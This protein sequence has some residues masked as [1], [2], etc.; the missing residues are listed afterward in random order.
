MP[1]S[2]L[3]VKIFLG[4]WV[5]TIAVLGSW[6]L[7]GQY[8][9][10]LVPDDS[11][12]RHGETPPRL[13]VRLLYDLQNQTS[14]K[15]PDVIAEAQAKRGVQVYFLDASG[16]DILGRRV[17]KNVAT[18]AAR[19]DTGDRRAFIRDNAR[20]LVAHQLYREDLGPMRSVLVLKPSRSRLVNELGRNL[21]LRGALAVLVSGLLC[22]LLSR[23]LT[24]RLGGLRQ[25]AAKLADGDLAVRLAV[26]GRGGDET[27]DLARDFNRMAA[28]LQQRIDAQRRLLAD[29]SHEL[30]SPLA[31]LRV[32]LA[33]AEQNPTAAGLQLERIEREASRLDELIAEL[34][35]SQSDQLAMDEHIDLVPLLRDLC[36]DASFEGRESGRRVDLQTDC[37]Q[38][39]VLGDGGRLRKAFDNVLR[40]ALY[41]S[42]RDT[43]VAVAISATAG[44]IRVSVQ[45]QGPGIP[46]GELERIFD[47]F[48]RVDSARARETGGYGLGLAIAR[49]A[50]IQHGGTIT[51]RNTG[52]GLRMDITLP[53]FDAR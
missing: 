15:L 5:V 25:A 36:N 30:R 2:S 46:A 42:P 45:D 19:L 22:Y 1:A 4:F 20:H 8:L 49:R 13:V 38:A 10:S 29:V 3:F 34:L 17:P 48:Y 39:L 44:E 14:E 33:L 12:A 23:L 35:R 11:H 16:E 21:W 53:L 27:D 28:Q 31:R 40:N 6:L 26:R 32:A 37:G 47:E 41:Y 7:A 50:I 9:D 24:R 51:A 43:V 52:P 18:V